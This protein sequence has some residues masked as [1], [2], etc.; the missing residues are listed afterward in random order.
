MIRQSKQ[1][2][3]L[4]K[5]W[6]GEG[7]RPVVPEKAQA[8]ANVC[9]KCPKNIDGSRLKMRDAIAY[10]VTKTIEYRNH[11]GMHVEGENALGVCLVCDCVLKL[12]VHVP[13][14]HIIETT[15]QSA[16]DELPDFC[17]QKT[18]RKET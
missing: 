3:A 1:F 14:K 11:L 18:E 10:L 6:L 12:K 4:H 13:I 15:P 9:L 5:A 7:M 2:F 8:R 16:I 17:W